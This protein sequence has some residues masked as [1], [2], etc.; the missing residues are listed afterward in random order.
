MWN[1]GLNV[2]TLGL[3]AIVKGF[4]KKAVSSFAETLEA[5]PMKRVEELAEVRLKFEAVSETVMGKH[6]PGSLAKGETG[7]RIYGAIERLDD[8]LDKALEFTRESSVK[9]L[10]KMPKKVDNYAKA[11]EDQLERLQVPREMLPQLNDPKTYREVVE[12]LKTNKAL[13]DEVMGAEFGKKM[14][15]EYLT[16][17]KSGGLNM[18]QVWNTLDW[19]KKPAG[20]SNGGKVE[21]PSAAQGVARDLRRALAADRNEIL[22]QSYSKSDPKTSQFMLDAMKEYNEK[23]DTIVQF[24]DIF[25]RSKE[26]AEKFTDAIVRPNNSQQVKDFRDLVGAESEEFG[27]LQAEWFDRVFREAINDAGAVDPVYLKKT[28]AKYG[29]EVVNEMVSPTQRHALEAVVQKAAKI[30]YFDIINATQRDK[31][32]LQDLAA[33]GILGQKNPGPIIRLFWNVLGSNAEAAKY[34]ADDGLL[35]LAAKTADP[36][37]K[38]LLLKVTQSFRKMLDATDIV[39]KNGRKVLEPMDFDKRLQDPAVQKVILDVQTKQRSEAA[40]KGIRLP[41]AGAMTAGEAAQMLTPQRE[42]KSGTGAAIR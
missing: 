28:M 3:G 10:G 7:E 36:G 12:F 39:D 38:S 22:S 25:R 6:R 26:S 29:D 4:G 31:Q 11:I 8:R 27:L 2:A 40:K 24:K 32:V 16:L 35:E 34:L 42:Q 33:I 20:Y 19:L 1:T 30:P 23:V 21:Y 13:G 14:I 5:A 15:D 9:D 18:N 41:G 37:K 17:N